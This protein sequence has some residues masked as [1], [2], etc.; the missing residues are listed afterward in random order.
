MGEALDSIIDSYDKLTSYVSQAMKTE[1]NKSDRGNQTELGGDEFVKYAEEL[2]SR[3]DIRKEL[4]KIEEL[5]RTEVEQKGIGT[6]TLSSGDADTIRDWDAV[7]RFN[8]MK[9]YTAILNGYK[10]WIEKKGIMKDFGSDGKDIDEQAANIFEHLEKLRKRMKGVKRKTMSLESAIQAASVSH[11]K[12]D[13]NQ[14][15][16]HSERDVNLD[17]AMLE[18]QIELGRLKAEIGFVKAAVEGL[19]K[20]L[21]PDKIGEF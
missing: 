2:T 9:T 8:D 11:S 5:Y 16:R 20:V 1:W 19:K 17:R 7:L 4:Q 12:R 6:L 13:A 15:V 18:S 21:P 3:P 14:S 10:D